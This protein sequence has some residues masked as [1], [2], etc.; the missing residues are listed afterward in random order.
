MFNQSEHGDMAIAKAP[1]RH[2]GP[3]IMFS[4]FG[5][6]KMSK[7]VPGRRNR[8]AILRVFTQG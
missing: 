1:F 7:K 4:F 2:L 3:L 5:V 8:Q 6:R